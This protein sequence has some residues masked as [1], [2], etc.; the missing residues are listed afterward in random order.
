VH[1]FQVYA[2]ESLRLGSIRQEILAGLSDQILNGFGMRFGES[3]VDQREAS[4]EI[5]HEDVTGGHID[6]LLQEG[7]LR[8]QVLGALADQPRQFGSA[9]AQLPR[10][11]PLSGHGRQQEGHPQ[12]AAKPGG[13][14]EMGEQ[15][16]GQRGALPVPYAIVVGGDHAEAVT[17]GRQVGVIR[18]A[19]R[20]RI[21]PI[22]VITFELDLEPYAGR[23]RQAQTGVM[24]FHFVVAGGDAQI[25]ERREP[26]SIGHHFLDDHGRD[27]VVVRQAPWV[28]HH[29]SFLGGEPEFAIPGAAAGGLRARVGSLAGLHAVGSVV[30]HRP[31]GGDSAVAEAIQIPARRPV[32]AVR[33]TDPEVAVVVG[34]SAGGVVVEEPILLG[35]M[36]D[37]AVAQIEADQPGSSAAEPQAAPAV[38]GDGSNRKAGLLLP[39][40]IGRVALGE[41]KQALYGAEPQGAG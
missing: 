28:D 29:N 16:E 20:V 39:R 17:A 8:L 11:E 38:F 37:P 35:V 23:N 24:E 36:G 5:F 13:L 6:D 25:R 41:F 15:H 4:R 18:S 30:V 22:A 31:H 14:V 27:A 26:V 33:G 12:R 9:R 2:R 1:H 3:P 19:A 21:H 34:E 10:V 7:L 32:D 40:A